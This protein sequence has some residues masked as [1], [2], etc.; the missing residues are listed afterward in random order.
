MYKI[1]NAGKGFTLLELLVVV[2]I[3]GIL[4]AIA[5]PQY[6]LAVGKSKLSTLKNIVKSTAESVQRYYM[7]NNTIP[8]KTSD[9][10]ISFKTTYEN[11]NNTL[12]FKISGDIS[13]IIWRL[14]D[15]L[16]CGRKIFGTDIYIYANRSGHF[17][18]CLAY[19]TDKTDVVN[20][21]CKNDTGH[22]AKRCYDSEGYCYYLY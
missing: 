6:Q 4:T 11:Y 17:T 12:G 7:I 13:C 9:M 14:E 2:L 21:I 20:N 19:S 5:L 1:K 22:N 16:A 15:K 18:N 10:D 3:I 8:K